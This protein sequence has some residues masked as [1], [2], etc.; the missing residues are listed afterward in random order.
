MGISTKKGAPTAAILLA[1]VLA[2]APLVAAVRRV[3]VQVREDVLGG[4]IWGDAGAYE[5]LSGRVYFS[6]RP[7]DPHN[8]AVVAA[9]AVVRRDAGILPR[10]R[11]GVLPPDGTPIRVV[12]RLAPRPVASPG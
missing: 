8:R 2:A 1:A 3:D 6:V 4:R 9:P 10:V 7:G 11:P 5:K 12:L